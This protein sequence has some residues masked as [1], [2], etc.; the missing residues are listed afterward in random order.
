ML[1]TALM[2]GICIVLLTIAETVEVKKSL[3]CKT[4]D[5]NAF[6]GLLKINLICY[7]LSTVTK[8]P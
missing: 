3:D 5:Q 8:L 4:V 6:K 1:T 7:Y 2:I